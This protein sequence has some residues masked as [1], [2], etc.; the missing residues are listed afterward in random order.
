M[1]NI[2]TPGG[3]QRTQQ[4][5]TYDRDTTRRNVS[6]CAAPHWT[7]A[8]EAH[9]R[10]HSTPQPGGR[11]PKHRASDDVSASLTPHPEQAQPPVPE[12]Q[13]LHP[14]HVAIDRAFE[15]QFARHTAHRMHVIRVHS[16]AVRIAL[17][18]SAQQEIM[19]LTDR[20]T[21]VNAQ[22]AQHA[23]IDVQIDACWRSTADT[24]APR[25]GPELP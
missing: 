3:D 9:Q 17:G 14:Y 25:H 22:T 5:S 11:G 10:P 18:F 19:E 8:Q 2:S 4:L 20:T 12:S 13:H 23:G 15:G 24:A 6:L 21:H 1:K 7:K 16:N